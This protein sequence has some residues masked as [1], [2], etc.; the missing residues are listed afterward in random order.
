[1]NTSV[2]Q[3][4]T[5]AP[6]WLARDPVLPQRDLLLDEREV[7]NRLSDLL[8]AGG[9]I[10]IGHC[11]KQRIKYRIGESLRVLYHID[12]DGRNH[13]VAARTSATNN[14]ESNSERR[15]INSLLES[16]LR[17]AVHDSEL[18]IDFWLYPNDRKINGLEAFHRIPPSL[19]KI[20]AADWISS[21]LVAYSPEKCATARCLDG[22]GAVIG[23][24]KIYAGDEGQRIFQTY[25]ALSA[26]LAGNTCVPRIARAL[27]YSKAHRLL[28]LE[29]V[30]GK[31]VAD[32][33]GADLLC[34]F[35]SLGSM[36]ALL[37]HC[38]PPEDVPRFKRLDVENLQ[39]AA[40]LISQAR[41]DVTELAFRL[42]F[43]LCSQL[44]LDDD[45][46]CLHGDVH[47]K[48]GI[49]R[50]G[51]VT[52]IDLDQ[53]AVGLPAADIGSLL[54]ACRYCWCVGAISKSDEDAMVESFLGGYQSVRRLPDAESLR[55]HVAAALLG[56]RALRSVNRIRPE[57]LLHLQALLSNAGEILH[58]KAYSK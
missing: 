30:P 9:P 17:S 38:S 10:T 44:P 34:G 42:S 26:N 5:S 12:V 21:E 15:V 35:H 51:E 27:A 45:V 23:Y 48:N 8:S 2:F 50:N 11:K 32:L 55:W 41:P 6:T 28:L 54:A 31:R 1:M 3:Q 19:S 29:A 39:K 16:G 24:A 14:C 4:P 37:H 56:E 53:A 25:S 43:E 46:V 49:V 20:G 57:G 47:P 52:L 40:K 18:Q 33:K 22:N 58:S 13:V 7:A 36:L